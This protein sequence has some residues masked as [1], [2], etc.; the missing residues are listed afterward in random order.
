MRWGILGCGKI[1]NDFVNGL[2]SVPDA[3]VEACAARSE[4]SAKSFGE[5]HG[6]VK[7]F[8]SYETLCQDSNVDIV[9]IGTI[10]TKHY[11]HAKLALSNGKHVL[12]EKPMAMNLTQATDLVNFAREKQLFLMEGMWTRFFPIVRKAR[13]LISQGAIGEIVAVNADFGVSIGKHVERLWKND[14][15]GGAL[16]D[17]GIYPV[18]FLSMV[19]NGVAPEKVSVAGAITTDDEKVDYFSNITLQYA[20]NRLGTAQIT[21]IATTSEVVS[22]T[23]T[24]GRILIHS[25]AHVSERLTIYRFGGKDRHDISQEEIYLPIPEPQAELNFNFPGSNGFQFEAASVQDCISKGLKENPE[26]N[27]NESLTIIKILDE[28]RTQLGVK[29]ACDGI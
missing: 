13:E 11:E 7:C 9:Y 14:L 27:L 10:H 22:I 17:L 21:S 12:V 15:G 29:Y 3:K 28:C 2:K 1:S 16:L 6:I 4:S 19:F 8:D 18:A 25:P 20:E 23:G 24:K 26:Y 5:K